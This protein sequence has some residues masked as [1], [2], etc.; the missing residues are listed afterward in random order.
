MLPLIY[1]TEKRNAASQSIPTD[2]DTGTGSS[3][4]IAA[5]GGGIGGGLAALALVG[6]GRWGRAGRCAISRYAT[7]NAKQFASCAISGFATC[8]TRHVASCA[9]SRYPT[10]STRHVASCA[11]SGYTTRSCQ[12]RPCA[13]H[14]LC[15]YFRFTSTVCRSSRDSTEWRGCDCSEGMVTADGSRGVGTA[16]GETIAGCHEVHFSSSDYLQNRRLSLFE[17]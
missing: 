16:A 4:S 6:V 5:L 3:S 9:L 12:A 15:R 17:E 8:S 11:L 14:R 7:R 13:S 2:A 1:A 10:L